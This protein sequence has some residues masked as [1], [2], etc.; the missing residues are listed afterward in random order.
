MISI[1]ESKEKHYV[2][3][4]VFTLQLRKL[5]ILSSYR[6]YSKFVVKCLHVAR[7]KKL[8]ESLPD[9]NEVNGSSFMDKLSVTIMHKS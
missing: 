5:I 7:K 6:Y 9:K 2:R 8:F 4:I 3:V 1:S